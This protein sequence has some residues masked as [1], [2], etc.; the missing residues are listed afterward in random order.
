MRISAWASAEWRQEEFTCRSR[1]TPSRGSTGT[2]WSS[3]VRARL[4]S[5]PGRSS[6]ARCATRTCSRAHGLSAGTRRSNRFLGERGAEGPRKLLGFGSCLL[7]PHP[8]SLARSYPL[9]LSTPAHFSIVE[10]GGPG[11]GWQWR[12]QV[13]AS[14]T[15]KVTLTK[16]WSR[17][18]C[19]GGRAVSPISDRRPSGGKR[20]GPRG[21]GA[22]RDAQGGCEAIRMLDNSRG[23]SPAQ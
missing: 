7:P 6:S 13:P 5:S 18:G 14:L 2:R 10:L 1:N 23:S 8:G 20:S 19:P 9:P 12:G 16:P 4:P 21:Q 11:P 15:D 3:R 22:R 17:R